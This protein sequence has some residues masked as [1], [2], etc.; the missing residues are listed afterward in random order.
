MSRRDEMC[1]WKEVPIAQRCH[2]SP[3]VPSSILPCCPD[4]QQMVSE[5]SLLVPPMH[6]ALGWLCLTCFGLLVPFS[7]ISDLLGHY[8]EYFLCLREGRTSQTAALS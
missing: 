7:G 5:E 2:R 1:L 8:S 3:A 6:P 4:H